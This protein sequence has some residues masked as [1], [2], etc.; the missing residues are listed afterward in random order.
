MLI[1]KQT[2]NQQQL[3]NQVI[4]NVK[5]FKYLGFTVGAKNC[6]LSKTLDDLAIKAKRVIFVLNNRIKL[7]KLRLALKM[8]N[9]QIYPIIL[10]GAEVWG[11]YLNI[12]FKKCEKTLLK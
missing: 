12:N 5:H 6:N 2:C 9:T 3:N 4:D 1:K 11:P 10:Y 7:S 8:F